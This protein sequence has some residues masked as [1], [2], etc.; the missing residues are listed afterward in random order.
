MSEP[1]ATA[2]VVKGRA[3]ASQPFM[4]LTS[5][6]GAQPRRSEVAV[7]KN[8]LTEDELATLNRMVSAFLD[9]AELR[10]MRH[11]PMYMRDRIGE[12]DDFATRYG[13][14]VL[15]GPGG[16]SHDAALAHAT[17]EHDEHRK[18][19]ADEPSPAEQDYLDAIKAAQETVEQKT[20]PSPDEGSWP[21]RQLASLPGGVFC[22][23]RSLPSTDV[24]I[25]VARPQKPG[26]QTSGR[27]APSI[28]RRPMADGMAR[29]SAG[30]RRG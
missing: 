27:E 10:A 11:V 13:K 18:H 12:L 25:A 24:R 16:V 26:R 20:R 29:A 30:A 15:P 14:G 22:R 8:Y 5:F 21:A 4:G 7:A 3:D 1:A 17:A 28:A 23:T 6:S 2:E 9:L 19:V